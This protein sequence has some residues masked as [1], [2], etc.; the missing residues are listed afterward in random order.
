MK[1]NIIVRWLVSLILS[2]PILLFVWAITLFFIEMKETVI[3]NEAVILEMQFFAEKFAL[4]PS[5]VKIGFIIGFIA[6]ILIDVAI[7]INKDKIR[8]T[9]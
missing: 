1:A 7:G 8:G 5:W 4:I 9:L 3:M 2:A 6:T